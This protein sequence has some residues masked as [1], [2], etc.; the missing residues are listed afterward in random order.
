MKLTITR[1]VHS[2]VTVSS[3]HTTVVIDPGAFGYPDGVPQADAVLVSHDHFDHVDLKRLAQSLQENPDLVV[4]SPTALDLEFGA[5]RVTLVAEGDAFTV[6][7]LR[8]EVVGKE[9]AQASL[10]DG[11]IPNVGYLIAGTVLHPGDAR[12]DTA[13]VPVV[14]TALAAPW[15]NNPQL[16][17]H[18]RRVKPGTVI[19]IHDATLSDLGREFAQLTLKKIADSYGGKAITMN[20]GDSI[21]VDTAQQ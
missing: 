17:E 5:D 13:E 9:Q 12:Q 16:E 11:P 7:E 19:G 1:G 20:T 15:Q 14:F 3:P 4:Y 2:A 8:I 10:D 6:G 18:L 21:T